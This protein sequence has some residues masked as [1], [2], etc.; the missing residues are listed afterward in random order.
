MSS[1]IVARRL[2]DP[3]DLARPRRPGSREPRAPDVGQLEAARRT[4]SRGS[5]VTSMPSLALGEDVVEG[6]VERPLQHEGA[7]DHRDPEQDRERGQ[8]AAQLARGEPPQREGEHQP[9]AT[10]PRRHPM[11]R[12]SSITSSSPP[13]RRSAA[14]C[15]VGEDDHPVRVGGD[16]RVVGD[17]DDRLAELVDRPPQQLEHAGARLRV[18]VAGRLVGEDD[19]GRGDQRARDR[20]A[21]LLAAGELGRAVRRRDRRDR[22]CRAAGRARPDRRRA[23]AICSGSSTFSAASSTGTRLK[24]WKMKPSFSRRSVGQPLVVERR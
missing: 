20:D 17:D 13:T 6:R 15:A 10:G 24:N 21:L 11:S 14:T 2:L 5:T 9:A 12:I 8:D 3:V 7:G 1:E 22:R 18:E 23:P 4:A 16:L 19:G